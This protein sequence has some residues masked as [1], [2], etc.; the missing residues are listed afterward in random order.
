MADPEV[1]DRLDRI[2]TALSRLTA[3]LDE[4]LPLARAYLDPNQSGARGAFMR[5]RLARIDGNGAQP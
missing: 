1:M 3:A 2:D 5:R 4:F